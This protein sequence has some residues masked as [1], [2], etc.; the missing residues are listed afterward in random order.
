MSSSKERRIRA[1]LTIAD[2]EYRLARLARADFP[3][4][5]TYQLQQAA[6]KLTRCRLELEDIPAGTTHNLRTLGEMLPQASPFHGR[7]ERL[8]D[9]SPAATRFRYPTSHG[10]LADVDPRDLDHWIDEVERLKHDVEAY[11]ASKSKT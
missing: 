8:D 2:E 1:F 5:A 10:G 4:Q 7:L 11:V 6:E 9:L 3:R